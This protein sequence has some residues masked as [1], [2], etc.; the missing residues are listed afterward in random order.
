M[1]DIRHSSGAR[2][3][4][5]GGANGPAR[6]IAR[7]RTVKRVA[8][9]AAIF[10]TIVVLGACDTDDILEVDVPGKVPEA[11]LDNPA[12]AQ[13][14]V[15]GALSDFECAWDNYV[16]A[17]AVHSDQFIH[18]S[19]NLQH[20]LWGQRR[21]TADDA[22]FAQGACQNANYGL[23]TPLQ[24]ARYQA[25]DIYRRVDA[26]PDAQVPQKVSFKATLRAYEGFSMVAFGEGFCSVAFD[27]GAELQPAQVLE[28]A[29]QRFTEAIT[30]AQQANNT[31]ILNMAYVGRA[32]VRLN[33]GNF[34]GAIEDA[35]RVPQGYVKNATR[36]ADDPRRF[37]KH[38]EWVNG[39]DWR[40]AT[41]APANRNLQWKG[42]ADPRV[43]VTDSGRNGFDAVTPWFYH[44]KTTG[45]NTPVL[46][47]S[48]KEA[49][50]FI[51][52][53]AARTGDLDRARGVINA[54]HQAAGIPLVDASDAP[55]QDAMIRLV[56][57][58]RNRELFA[59]GG[60]RLND[61]LRFRGT[62]FNIPFK[63]EAGSAYPNGIDH[64]GQPYG[65]TTCW[66]LPTV[67]R[68][69]NP[70]IQG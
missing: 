29:E 7:R 10:A 27:G 46:L 26:F 24:S 23:Y 12:L 21:I 65:N 30:L 66:P 40:H 32:R 34:A 60:H 38:H 42:V 51:A 36:S 8:G 39:P 4:T 20:R 68:N 52:E 2:A 13:T 22:A 48:Y 31:D 33:R 35:A 14:L 11:A 67:E 58:E 55:T 37:N 62:P 47:A 16:G 28:L 64:L 9:W 25:A 56:L 41:V 1:I 6:A 15:N 19:G 17:S 54:L 63:G 5:G 3:G 61:H 43:D 49:Q 70:N 59:E 57:E 50:L 18:S 45:R 69:G 44:Q 53:A